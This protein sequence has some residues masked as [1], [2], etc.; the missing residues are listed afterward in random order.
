METLSKKLLTP[1]L[2]GI[3]SIGSAQEVGEYKVG[4]LMPLIDYENDVNGKWVFR[5]P[6]KTAYFLSLKSKE[7]GQETYEVIYEKC[8]IM[9]KIMVS[10]IHDVQKELILIDNKKSLVYPQP[11]GRIDR[12][13]NLKNPE[14]LKKPFEP[15]LCGEF[16]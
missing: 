6:E 13:V 9:P 11:D 1:F 14:E 3:L 12:I 10:L 16:F 15:V 8:N 2:I 5:T 4:G 7:N